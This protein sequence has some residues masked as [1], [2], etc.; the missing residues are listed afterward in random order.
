[1]SE[2]VG[3]LYTRSAAFYDAVYAGRRDHLAEAARLHAEIEAARRGGGNALLDV[4]CGTGAHLQHLAVWYAVA[5][6]DASP[7]ML[8]VARRRLPDAPFHH[9]DL[10]AFDLGRRVGAVVCLGSS[11]AYARTLPRLRQAIR[12]MAD[13]VE[14]G[15]V[16]VVEPWFAPDD[17][18]DGQ[19]AADLSD[20]PDVKVARVLVSGLAAPT[21]SAL[22]IHHLVATRDGIESFAERHEM[23]LFTAEEHLAAFADA[24][25]AARHDPIG[26]I[27]RGLYVAVKG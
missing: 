12:A 4:A 6:L 24:G 26:L 19:L 21:V 22:D 11:V 20:G 25:L 7:D 8:A 17:W 16:V 3:H 9:G 18:E 5:G 15:G 23:G 13:H 2:A 1:M 10:A 27:G 14:D